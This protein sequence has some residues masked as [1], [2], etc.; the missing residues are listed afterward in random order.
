A[1]ELR[2]QQKLT[3]CLTV[4][5]R[6]SDFNTYTQQLAIPYTAS[7]RALLNCAKEL[8]DKLYQR[9]QLVRLIGVK[10]SALVPGS[11][12]L[13]LFEDTGEE[14]RLLEQLD[15]IR[16]RFGEKAVRKASTLVHSPSK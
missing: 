16:R 15:H 11:Y 14:M 7:D 10:F 6:Y 4:K 13:N 5:I 1:F 2:Q 8:F 3:A 12:Q 9:R